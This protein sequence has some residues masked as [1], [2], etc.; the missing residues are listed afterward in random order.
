ML[1]AEEKDMENYL[2]SPIYLDRIRKMHDLET[3]AHEEQ[4]AT[5]KEVEKDIRTKILEELKIAQLEIANAAVQKWRAEE[6]K[7]IDNPKK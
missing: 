2:L 3:A 5:Q 6:L 7:K 4:L 1:L